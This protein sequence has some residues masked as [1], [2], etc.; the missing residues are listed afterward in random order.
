MEQSNNTNEAISFE[1]H[2]KLVVLGLAVG[3]SLGAT[4]EFQI[5]WEVG[6]YCVDAYP[7]WPGKIVGGGVCEWPLGA[8]TDDTDMALCILHALEESKGK[9]D[10][11]KIAQN[12]VAWKLTNPPDIGQTTYMSLDYYQ[13]SLEDN[14][15]FY[16]G[17]LHLFDNGINGTTNAA[18]GSLMR[19]GMIPGIYSNPTLYS[20]ETALNAT[21]AH[22]IIT[23]YGP[24]PVL[25]CI[26]HTLLIRKVLISRHFPNH[27]EATKDFHLRAPTTS[28]LTDLLINP[29][30]IW[31]TYKSTTSYEPAKEW[32][33][34]IGNTELLQIEKKLI[35]DL[36]SY[37]EERYDPYNQ[38]YRGRASYCVLTL[39]ISL[40]GALWSFKNSPTLSKPA[41][42]PAWPFERHQFDTLMWIV[43][44]GA[45]A[46][47]YGAA[48]GPLLAAY[49]P[50]IS[51][52]FLQDLQLSLIHI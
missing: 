10:E 43:L 48:A 14:K 29:K 30:G 21:I 11:H 46:D 15:S 49:H 34:K 45:D 38:D 32:L 22:G 41:W 1:D 24:E 18:N 19:N 28:D 20:L 25:T 33:K 52:E 42:L 5:P 51:N 4:S 17:G 12:F 36:K 27:N 9:L 8:P 39:Q 3:D 40:W 50:K 26:L 23:H 31:Q 35:D 44:I 16:I 13:N 7:G 6:K 37:E 47:T 2:Q